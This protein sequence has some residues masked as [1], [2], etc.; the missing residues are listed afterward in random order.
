[1]R[2]GQIQL[3]ER[4]KKIKLN[5]DQHTMLS[6]EDLSLNT[7]LEILRVFESINDFPADKAYEYVR[8]G[9]S[10]YNLW[11]G[12]KTL[13]TY[14][15]YLSLPDVFKNSSDAMN[16]IRG[17]R[18]HL[19]DLDESFCKTAGWFQNEFGTCS[20]SYFHL[21]DIISDKRFSRRRYCDDYKLDKNTL[22]YYAKFYS[23]LL[24]MF[25]SQYKTDLSLLLLIKAKQKLEE[26]Y[27]TEWELDRRQAQYD[28]IN[29]QELT[30]SEY[31]DFLKEKCHGRIY[32]QDYINKGIS[33]ETA[34]KT[35]MEDILAAEDAF[36]PEKTEYFHELFK[37]CEEQEYTE[38]QDEQERKNVEYMRDKTLLTGSLNIRSTKI[39]VSVPRELYEDKPVFIEFA[40]TNLLKVCVNNEGQRIITKGYK[41]AGKIIVYENGSIYIKKYSRYQQA[42]VRDIVM[43]FHAYHGMEILDKILEIPAIKDSYVYKDLVK[44]CMETINAHSSF[45]SILWNSC[46]G[47]KNRNQ[48]MK[49]LYKNAEDIDFNKM[50]IPCGYAYMKTRPYVDDLSQGILYNAFTQHVLTGYTCKSARKANAVA[51]AVV[52]EYLTKKLECLYPNRRN[53]IHTETKDYVI[54][55]LDEKE[56]LSLRWRSIT[57][58]T[59]QNIDTVLANQNSKTAKIMIPKNSKF[60]ALA[61]QLPPDFEQIR[62]RKRI[63][64]EGKLMRH[65]VASYA[66][67]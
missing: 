67:M 54:N 20:I 28:R 14:K 22:I 66:D 9:R 26:D 44:D 63:I 64:L 2:K 38:Y 15:E 24:A 61:Q 11:T 48:L 65:C 46:M 51:Q 47:Y 37:G 7:L 32:V 17:F 52:T 42:T 16:S 36:N 56:K 23:S 12:E 6:R 18:S 45:P 41:N 34:A 59:Q 43:M 40:C 25:M 57:K 31:I 35:V 4:A 1:M 39:S 53:D 19:Q 5:K 60:N 8:L 58:M 55:T 62:T 3:L 33:A 10:A 49:S 13:L 21:P 30:E 29:S 27:G 50:G